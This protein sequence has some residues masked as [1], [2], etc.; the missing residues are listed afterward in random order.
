M[1]PIISA[2]KSTSTWT[3]AS[4]TF[5]CPYVD[6]RRRILTHILT[7]I[8]QN[9]HKWLFAKRG[10][11]V[12]YVP[13]RNQ[14]IVRA[15]FPTS[16]AYISPKDR[17]E[18]DYNFVEQFECR[19]FIDKYSSLPFVDT[20]IGNG[21]ID[22][23]PL[24]SIEAA[25]AF[26]SWLGG[27]HVINAYTHK[28]AVEGGKRLA[29]ILGTKVLDEDGEFTESMANVQL[30]IP[31]DYSYPK[32]DELLKRKLLLE[33]KMFAAPLYH[34]RLWWV[35]CSAQVWLEVSRV[36]DMHDTFYLTSPLGF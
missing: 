36:L 14:H 4:P 10:A 27:E 25:F 12:L 8:A 31:L 13:K 35:R 21:T 33:R 16:F 28:L 5:G 7:C 30:P 24:L 19:F 1:L 26:R 9:C 2:S 34:N 20:S 15:S 29:Q 23:V 11:A 17:K 32:I 22:F 6:V 18:G 3:N